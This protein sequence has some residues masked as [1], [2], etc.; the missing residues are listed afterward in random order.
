MFYIGATGRYLHL[1]QAWNTKKWGPGGAAALPSSGS[2]QVDGF[3]FDAGAAL[4]LGKIVS[5][6]V[7]GYNL[8]NTGSVYA[9]I[10]LGTGIALS[11]LD[12]LILEG[13]VVLDF[14]SHESVNTELEVGTELFVAGAVGIRAGYDYD[15]FF[16]TH[17]VAAGLGYVHQ[18]F[19]IDAGFTH[20][21]KEDGRMRL[22]FAFKYFVN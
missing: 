7:V 2:Q 9:P 18:K 22:G 3:T 11:L 16:N 19:G 20:E 17:S 14:T 8:T 13:D 21:I 10:E 15:V 1:D 12:I 5:I 4:R 6:G